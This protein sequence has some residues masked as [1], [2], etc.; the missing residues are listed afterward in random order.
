MKLSLSYQR[1]ETVGAAAE[2]HWLGRHQHTHPG[3]YR[4]HVTARTAR[5]TAAKRAGWSIPAQKNTEP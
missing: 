2:V 4:N 1:G 5:S 3:R